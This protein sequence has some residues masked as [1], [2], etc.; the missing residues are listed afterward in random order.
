MNT[1]SIDCLGTGEEGSNGLSGR[2]LA[3]VAVENVVI[4]TTSG[5]VESLP[6]A[7]DAVAP[8]P[9]TLALFGIG[10]AGLIGLGRRR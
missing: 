7:V 8:E 10:L 5:M 6:D 4:D 9:G 3:F 2:G 1:V